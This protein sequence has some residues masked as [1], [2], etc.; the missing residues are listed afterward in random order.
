M[1]VKLT[2]KLTL[3]LELAG[4]SP[5]LQLKLS[6]PE[7]SVVKV[8]LTA[9]TTPPVAVKLPP[10]QLLATNLILES[11]VSLITTPVKA[12]VWLFS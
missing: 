9:L 10:P 12:V 5:T 11:S 2:L 8:Q 4:M 1:L 7:E 6:L 3:P